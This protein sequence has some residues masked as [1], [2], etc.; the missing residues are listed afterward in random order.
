MTVSWAGPD[1]P[2]LRGEEASGMASP[3]A[4]ITLGELFGQTVRLALADLDLYDEATVEYLTDLLTRFTVTQELF[5]TGSS[6]ARLDTTGEVLREI[7]RSW[8][9]EGPGFDPER[10]IALRRHLGD[11]T[12]FIT[13]F[14]WERPRGAAM[15]RHYIRLGRWAYRFLADHERARES[16]RAKLYRRLSDHFESYAGAL[17][18]LREV[19]LDANLAPWPH[20]LLARLTRPR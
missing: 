10:E 5:P 14:F 17:T 2:M 9:L 20:P 7:Q 11:T 6:G 13:G 18:Y 3:A 8:Q 16:P 1:G 4:A 15:K 19:Y 12:L